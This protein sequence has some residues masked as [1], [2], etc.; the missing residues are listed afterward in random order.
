MSSPSQDVE[1]DQIKE[2]LI[3]ARHVEKYLRQHADFLVQHPQVIDSLEIPGKTEGRGLADLQQHMIEKLRNQLAQVTRERDVVISRSHH[4]KLT[5]DRTHRAVTALISAKNFEHLIDIISTELPIIMGMDAIAIGVEQPGDSDVAAPVEGISCLLAGMVDGLIGSGQPAV[6]RSHIQGD[7][8][9]YGTMAPLIQSDALV[10]LHISS[11]TP[12][13]MLAFGSQRD[14]Q[15]E[16][17]Q[18]TELIRFIGSVVENT[19]RTW[20]KLPE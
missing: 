6:L 19:I 18:G 1:T 10:R 14:D 4:N 16:P 3:T 9:L 7:V 11:T 5:Q 8:C 17:G 2:P 13:A 20:L 15:F 12:P